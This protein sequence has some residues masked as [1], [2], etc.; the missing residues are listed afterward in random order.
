[1]KL[2]DESLSIKM[3]QTETYHLFDKGYQGVWRGVSLELLIDYAKSGKIP[4]IGNL[5]NFIETGTHQGS[6][7]TKASFLFDKVYTTEINKDFKPAHD[8]IK[9][10]KPN[11]EFHYDTSPLF[12]KN[13]LP[14]IKEQ[15]VIF[16]DAHWYE[17]PAREE[18][19][20]IKKYST[21]NDH[22]IIIDDMDTAG[23]DLPQRSEIDKLLNFINPE[24]KIE[25]WEKTVNKNLVAYV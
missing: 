2:D 24:Y 10:Y 4:Y 23:S 6:G 22:V 8:A 25:L 9:R 7:A 14:K 16:L 15:S 1:M 20:N 13:L 12:L 21:R 3:L 11:I 18:L 19:T 5:N 17:N